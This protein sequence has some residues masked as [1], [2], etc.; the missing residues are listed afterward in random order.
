MPDLTFY[1]HNLLVDT[2]HQNLKNQKAYGAD[3]WTEFI[4]NQHLVDR[5]YL[6]QDIDYTFNSQGYRTKEIGELDDN[7]VLV[8]GCSHTEGIGNFAKDIWCS[9]LLDSK[10]ID[11]LNLG[12]AGTGPDVQYFNTLQWIKNSFPR[13]RLV[14]YQWPQDF[15]RSFV[16]YNNSDLVF[17][18]Y[19][20]HS[21]QEKRDTGWYHKR[22]CTEL[23]EMTKDG[24]RDYYS[25]NT[26]WQA[27]Q[28][29]VLNWTWSG[30]F[31]KDFEDL[32]VIETV[33][34]GRARDL[35]H[36]GADI[37]NQI[38]DKLSSLIDKLL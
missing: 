27:L 7:F 13:P 6:Q 30:D 19:N 8:F 34:T 15:R 4:R 37:H 31:E 23:G 1:K 21:K 17:R 32:H 28:V 2:Q 18:H 14:I 24:Y 9:Q 36:D 12:K 26:L 29:P 16:Y 33:D 22:Y 10:G 11:F 20:V 3:E 35:M 38:A 25:A 5:K